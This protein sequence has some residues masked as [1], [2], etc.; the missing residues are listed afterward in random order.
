M[1]FPTARSKVNY[2]KSF[3]DL[4]RLSTAPFFYGNAFTLV[5]TSTNPEGAGKL[6][7][8]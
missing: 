5:D 3:S 7:V 4:Y 2:V 6:I 8:N 1:K